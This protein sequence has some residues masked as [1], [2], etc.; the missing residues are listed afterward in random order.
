[1]VK[2]DRLRVQNILEVGD[3]IEVMV[4]GKVAGANFKGSDTIRVNR[5]DQSVN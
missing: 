5:S 1:M 2:F 4:T 3:E